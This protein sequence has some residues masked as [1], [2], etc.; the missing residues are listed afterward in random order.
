MRWP[1]GSLIKGL[2]YGWTAGSLAGD[3]T[4]I[5]PMLQCPTDPPMRIRHVAHRGSEATC[6]ARSWRLR[7]AQKGQ[8]WFSCSTRLYSYNVMQFFFRVE[9]Q[10]LELFWLLP[11]FLEPQTPRLTFH[12]WDAPLPFEH[13]STLCVQSFDLWSFSIFNFCPPCHVMWLPVS[14][15]HMF[16]PFFSLRSWFRHPSYKKMQSPGKHGFH[17]VRCSLAKSYILPCHTWRIRG[18]QFDSFDWF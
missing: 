7:R 13:A 6:G 16:C 14:F 9:I 18:S 2:S 3:L 5:A 8:L 15:S 10:S 1:I 4:Q 12:S 17:T 11:G